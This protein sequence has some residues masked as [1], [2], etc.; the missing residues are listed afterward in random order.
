MMKRFG[1][2]VWSL[3]RRTC[4]DAT[5]AEDAVQEIF[6]EIWR[7]AGR[8]DSSIAGEATFVAMIA[9]RRLID[10]TRRRTRRPQSVALQESTSD[11][12]PEDDRPEILEQAGVASEAFEQLRPEQQQVLRLAIHHG[13]SHE[14]IATT[15]GMPLGTVK[16]HARR[17]LI[18]L[19]QLL[20]ATSFEMPHP[21]ASTGGN[22]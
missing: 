20:E 3:A 6:V 12:T 22:S 9:R 7:T 21:V 13:R 17:G 2:L 18:R 4:P 11:P 1:G 10:R 5:E 14:Q 15:T 8:F 19:R 16:T